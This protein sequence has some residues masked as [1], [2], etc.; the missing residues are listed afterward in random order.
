MN[1][2]LYCHYAVLSYLKSLHFSSHHLL[3]QMLYYNI[4]IKY[5]QLQKNLLVQC[6]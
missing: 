6:L 2:N 4:Y 5:L 1:Q 3:D